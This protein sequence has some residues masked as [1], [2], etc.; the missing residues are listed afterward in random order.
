MAKIK[1]NTIQIKIFVSFLA[2]LFLGMAACREEC[3]Y[4]PRSHAGVEFFSIIDGTAAEAGVNLLEL[5]GVGREDSLLYE[6]RTNIRAL[7]LP[8][9]GM[10][11]ETGFIFV[12]EEHTDT[13]WFRYEV[14]PFFLSQECGFMLNFELADVSY[15]T[16]GID[17]VVIVTRKITSFDDTNIRIYH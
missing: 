10:A 1:Q 4:K 5:K 3:H 7:S 6:N 14:I 17:S 12:F 8:M 15:T 2:I 13:V 11:E 9:N 16:A